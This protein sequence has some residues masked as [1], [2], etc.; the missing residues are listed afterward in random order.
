MCVCVVCVSMCGSECGVCV[1]VCKMTVMKVVCERCF[2]GKY[3]ELY[4]RSRILEGYRILSKVHN[5][6]L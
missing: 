2:F 3:Y 6:K 5:K 4:R 1:C